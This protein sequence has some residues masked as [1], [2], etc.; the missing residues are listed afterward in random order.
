[1]DTK[2]FTERLQEGIGA[3]ETVAV[4]FGH[5]QIDVEHVLL[6]LLEQERGLVPSILGKADIDV[7]ALRRLVEE[8]LGKM[9]KVS[10]ASAG[11]G[12]IYVTNRLTRLLTQADYERNT[13]G[14]QFISIEH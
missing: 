14:D 13:M 7:D 5:Q 8:E 10:G 4:R 2:K 11:P 1:M 12:Q 9:P 3:A 6:A